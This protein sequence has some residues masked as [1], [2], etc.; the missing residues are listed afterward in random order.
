MELGTEAYLIRPLSSGFCHPIRHPNCLTAAAPAAGP[1]VEHAGTGCCAS[2]ATTVGGEIPF[3]EV[4]PVAADQH[5]P[6][7]MAIRALTGRI[8]DV[9]CVDV[10]Q[11]VLLGD[12]ARH[13]QRGGRGRRRLPHLPV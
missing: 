8:V 4:V 11:P 9:A 2:L 7:R 10:A 6:A 5:R 1:A 12:A 3:V 13:A